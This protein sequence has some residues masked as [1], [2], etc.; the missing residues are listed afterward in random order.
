[1]GEEAGLQWDLLKVPVISKGVLAKVK[2]FLSLFQHPGIGFVHLRIKLGQV[3]HLL[4]VHTSVGTCP[5]P[6]GCPGCLLALAPR[7][8]E[9]RV[10]IDFVLELWL[11]LL[12]GGG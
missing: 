10:H 7:S 6:P 5:V 12:L 3:G 2:L 11:P 4:R 1:V 9:T 8:L